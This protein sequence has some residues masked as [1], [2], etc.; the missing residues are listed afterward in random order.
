MHGNVREW[1]QDT[2]HGDYNGAP[3]DGSA[4][5]SGDGAYRVIRG[6]SWCFNVRV[7]RSAF[8]SYGDPDVRYFAIGF[9][10]LEGT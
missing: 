9:R 2:W 10:L 8:R 5:E 7:C 3:T 4:W 6:G 1:T